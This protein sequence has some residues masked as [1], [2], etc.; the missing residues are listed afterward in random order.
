M[1]MSYN[2]KS[3]RLT[4]RFYR[5]KGAV[6]TTACGSYIELFFKGDYVILHFDMSDLVVSYPL[7]YLQ[8]DNGDLVGASV[9]ARIYL[10]TKNSGS[11][12]LKIIF[13][14]AV[15]VQS[16]WYAP[17]EA[18]ISF[19]GYEAE[20]P[21]EL[22]ETNQKS[23]TFI[24]D[25]ITEGIL[26]HPKET[27]F[28]KKSMDRV[29]QNDVTR[30]YA[31]QIAE[32]FN[33]RPTFCG[34][35]AVGF[36]RSGSGDVPKAGDMYEYCVDGVKWEESYTPDYIM[37]NHGCNDR[38]AETSDY[39]NEYEKFLEYLVCKYPTTKII[40]LSPFIGAFH[41]ELAILAKNFNEKNNKDILYIDSFGWVPKDPLHP[42]V[43]GHEKIACEVIKI[44][45]KVKV[46]ED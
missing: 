29:Y 17:V 33:L 44:L 18:K 9:A 46:F 13:Q 39:L 2:D 11:H 31:W 42:L 4:G 5:E 6:S 30:T 22:D 20:Q 26:I 36:T 3:V 8:I 1:F 15:E 25:S 27:P 38:G 43:D 21:D 10:R 19:E 32:H 14:S 7:I 37:I 16:R 35:G 34:Y 23:I 28:G 12:K 40:M 41:E 24:G 45:E